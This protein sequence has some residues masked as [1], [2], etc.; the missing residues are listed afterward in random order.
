MENVTTPTRHLSVA[1]Y[2]LQ[3][4][5]EYLIADFRRKIYF[6]PKDKNY[7]TKVCGYKKTRI[8]KISERNRLNSIFNSEDKLNELRKELFDNFGKPKFLMT[9]NDV[10]NYYSNGNEFSYHGEIY[11]LD[12]VRQDGTFTIY[13]PSKEEYLTVNEEEISRIL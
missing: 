1:E 3:I 12:Q 10:K 11:I 2:F 7:W 5:K 8:E 4:E 13:S 6:S 9:E